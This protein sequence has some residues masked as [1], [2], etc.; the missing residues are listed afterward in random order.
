MAFNDVKILEV[1]LNNESSQFIGSQ[2]HNYILKLH[3]KPWISY[4]KKISIPTKILQVIYKLRL[5][6]ISDPEHRTKLLVRELLDRSLRRC[7]IIKYLKILQHYSFLS[8]KLLNLEEY[9]SPLQLGSPSSVP[10]Y[11]DIINMLRWCSSNKNENEIIYGILLGYYSGLHEP[12][13]CAITNENLV[14]IHSREP[15]I[16]IEGKYSNGW[17]VVYFD[18]LMELIYELVEVFKDK[19]KLYSMGITE[20]LFD[21][22]PRTF[23]FLMN[24]CYIKALGKT[25]PIGFC[26]R[27]MRYIINC[28]IKNPKI[29]INDINALKY[30]TIKPNQP[31][32]S[33]PQLFCLD[34][35]LK[36]LN[37]KLKRVSEMNFSINQYNND[38]ND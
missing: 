13:I 10:T 2:I 20:K 6:E 4:S 8:I 19:I 1:E 26:I 12:D 11:S 22:L 32:Q 37:R 3:K 18:E 14:Q 17:Q 9:I 21:V 5:H 7:T 16:S 15:L 31:I 28:L 34:K 24:Q 23:L 27:M 25:P 30:L 36:E 38:E 35:D 33:D 29:Q